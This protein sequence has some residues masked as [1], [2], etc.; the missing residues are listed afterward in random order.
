MSVPL[1]WLHLNNT[2]KFFFQESRIFTIPVQDDYYSNNSFSGNT[3]AFYFIRLTDWHLENWGDLLLGF[4]F[5]GFS[6]PWVSSR[7]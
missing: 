3:E 7:V 1:I 2:K 4:Y 6:K 5:Y